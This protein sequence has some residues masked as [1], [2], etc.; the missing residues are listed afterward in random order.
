MYLVGLE[1]G[2]KD[3]KGP[4]E[5]RF[6]RWE[7]SGATVSQ[8]HGV[9]GSEADA[10]RE[11]KAF[12]DEAKAQ[13]F[14]A[15][16]LSAH[17]DRGYCVELPFTVR[18]WEE[19]KGEIGPH[20]PGNG[21]EDDYRVLVHEGD[22]VIPHGLWLEYRR[23]LLALL[24]EDE[25]PFA[26]VY[27]RG[28][29]TIE[30]CLHNFENDYG[31]FLYVTSDLIAESV[32]TGGARVCVGGELRADVVIGVYNHGSTEAKG[33][34]RARVVASEHLVEGNPLD[35]IRY[36]GWGRTAYPVRG[37]VVDA[38]EPYEPKGIFV[39]AVLKNESVD[40]GKARQLAVAGKPIVKDEPVSVRAAFRKLI[41]KKLA[42]PDKVKSLS[43]AG[44][45]LT[46]LPEEIFA[47]RKLEKLDLTH[48]K[49]RQLPEEIGQL[50]ELRELNLTGNGL[51]DLPESIGQL[52]KLRVLTLGSNCLW[53]L[54][55][56]MAHCS[57]LRLVNLANNP[58]S[59]V[60]SAFGSW[61]KVKLMW[62]LPEVLTRLPRLEE[63][64]FDGIFIRKLH[65]RPFTSQHLRRATIKNSLVLN[66]DPALHG[67]LEVD[68]SKSVERAVNYVRYWF[69]PENL[70]LGSFYDSQRDAYDF[71][72]AIALLGVI[73]QI[74]I[75]TAAPYEASL[76]E[77]EKQIASVIRDL[78]WGGKGMNHAHALLGAL[79]AS[80]DGFEQLYPGN[81]LI[82]GLRT[83]FAPRM[84]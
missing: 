55:D 74:S 28:S 41:G 82:A 50:T 10:K 69:A 8:E 20:L 65:S 49:L 43:L 7:R 68:T 60:R 70:R 54:P 39:S 42:D 26:G 23:G 6:W 40:L 13:A 77:F 9:V 44:K 33:P 31:P 73:L 57:E 3:G 32:A 18:T 83:R 30:G 25:E 61:S 72:E 22:A 36:S 53:R 12:A 47:F 63:L 84:G 16:Q 67:Q 4:R 80:L 62:E 58:Y 14:V 81:P 21:E 75:P 1:G 27:V 5:R 45:D 17:L 24:D 19:V 34:L 35:A 71:T 29:L 37:G 2:G 59:Y 51:T 76:A 79:G 48:N 78:T 11:S 66:V 56:S 52:G 64:I 38:S 15:K 46:S